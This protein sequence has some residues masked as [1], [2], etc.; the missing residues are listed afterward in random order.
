MNI[1]KAQLI[2][3]LIQARVSLQ[4]DIRTTLRDRHGIVAKYARANA[5]EKI[6]AYRLLS[7]LDSINATT[8]THSKRDI[9]RV[10]KALAK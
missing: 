8:Y 5:R 4:K 1:T 3:A 7:N 6:A 10:K 9:A 2:N